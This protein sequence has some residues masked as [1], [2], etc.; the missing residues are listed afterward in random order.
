MCLC[1]CVCVCVYARAHGYIRMLSSSYARV[2]VGAHVWACMPVCVRYML[3]RMV[4][5][6]AA[7][8]GNDHA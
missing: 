7:D 1:V 8:V 6:I 5:P 4:L 2:D 3:A